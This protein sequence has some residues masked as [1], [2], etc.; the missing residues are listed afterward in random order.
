MQ[1][2]PYAPAQP[3]VPTRTNGQQP[4]PSTLPP[5]YLNLPGLD[6]QTRPPSPAPQRPTTGAGIDWHQVALLRSQASDQLTAALGE[7]R[8]MDPETEKELGRAIIQELLQ[9]TAP[10]G[11]TTARAPGPWRSRT[12]SPKRSSTLCSG[13]AAFS[14]WSTTIRWRT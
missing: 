11:S 1:R 14:P 6:L 4:S 8:G 12:P 3:F 2:R 13:L 5:T 9:T 10:T 7:E